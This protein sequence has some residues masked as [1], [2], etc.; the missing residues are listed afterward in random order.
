MV[1]HGTSDQAVQQEDLLHGLQRF[2]SLEPSKAVFE[3]GGGIV[4][5]G[6]NGSLKAD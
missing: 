4:M 1:H 6:F 5:T 3:T 2:Q